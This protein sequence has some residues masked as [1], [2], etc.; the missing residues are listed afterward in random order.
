MKRSRI[1]IVLS[2]ILVAFVFLGGQAFAGGKTESGAANGAKL[3][4]V[5]VSWNEKI[6]SQIQ[7]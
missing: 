2:V 3:I 6:H 7:A 4:K 5:G 1:F